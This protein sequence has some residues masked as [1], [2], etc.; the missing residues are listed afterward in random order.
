[1][2][3]N[4]LLISIIYLLASCGGGSDSSSSESTIKNNAPTLSGELNIN[5]QAGIETRVVYT[6][7][8]K[9]ND[10]ISVSVNNLP[11]WVS[12]T[13]TANQIEFSINPTL[14]DVATHS[15]NLALSDNKAKT[16]YEF[17]VIVNENKELWG[18]HSVPFNELKGAWQTQDKKLGFHFFDNDDGIV[19]SNDRFYHINWDYDHPARGLDIDVENCPED[20]NTFDSI[21]FRVVAHEGDRIKVDFTD[22]QNQDS[23]VVLTKNKDVKVEDGYYVNLVGGHLYSFA[24]KI[25]MDAAEA[26]LN[27]SFA[28]FRSVSGAYLYPTL[29]I[30]AKLGQSNSLSLVEENLV[31]FDKLTSDFYSLVDSEDKELSFRAVATDVQFIPTIRNQLAIEL[32]YRFELTSDTQGLSQQEFVAQFNS[33]LGYILSNEYEATALHTIVEPAAA[34]SDFAGKTYQMMP[35]TTLLDAPETEI[36]INYGGQN[37]AFLD[38][39]KGEVELPFS[40]LDEYRSVPFNWSI[41]ADKLQ[42]SFLN[43]TQD[44]PFFTMPDGRL[45]ILSSVERGQGRTSLSMFPITELENSNSR[46]FSQDHYKQNFVDLTYG[47]DVKSGGLFR[48]DGDTIRVTSPRAEYF[49]Q[50]EANNSLSSIGK[51]YCPNAL[52]YLA[53]VEQVSSGAQSYSFNVYIYNLQLEKIDGDKYYFSRTTKQINPKLAPRFNQY[54]RIYTNKVSEKFLL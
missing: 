48:F 32:T 15:F 14:F 52:D 41:S 2:K 3:R 16:N 1:M 19:F 30:E 54:K 10:A 37:Y 5:T 26:K 36:G 4:L 8:D 40:V 42:L 21:R 46:A 35:F 12:Y 28:K 38:S 22:E 23:V 9:E 17:K 34:P 47:N 27:L 25:D 29:P 11:K 45:A 31:L 43:K 50:F 13:T 51:R 20:C 6:L 39:N 49:Y 7:D 33:S 24:S 18:F 44:F 53:C